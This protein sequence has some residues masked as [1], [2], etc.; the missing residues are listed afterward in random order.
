MGCLP[1]NPFHQN[2]ISEEP[3]T[4][5]NLCRPDK[6]LSFQFKT[7]HSL[8]PGTQSLRN[9][10]NHEV[11][12]ILSYNILADAYIGNSFSYCEQEFKDFSY[13]GPKIV[14]FIETLNP[15]VFCLQEVDHYNDYYQP[16]LSKNYH[17]FQENQ[18]L[19]LNVGLL[20]GFKKNAYKFLKK[21][22]ICYDNYATEELF[23]DLKE[24]IK[25]KKDHR[26][27]LLEIESF[28]NMQ[29][30]IIVNTH[31]H[32]NP[33]EEDVKQ[34]QTIKLIKYLE[35]RYEKSEEMGIL[36]HYQIQIKFNSIHSKPRFFGPENKKNLENL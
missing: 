5:E 36:I 18:D 27:L 10:I 31:L 25:F 17:L 7:M 1:S 21:T 29:K 22:V 3:L 20:I 26:A 14:K 23:E 24:L 8:I 6:S 4:T 9:L 2:E 33:A 30:Y 16:F 19:Y 11:L 12:K 15:D 32:W 35:N 28:K 34:F 13:R